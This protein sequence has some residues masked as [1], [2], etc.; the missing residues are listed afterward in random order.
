M[1]VIE[2]LKALLEHMK[3][4]SEVRDDIELIL[5]FLEGENEQ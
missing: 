4:T 3:E 2:R 5:E 1:D